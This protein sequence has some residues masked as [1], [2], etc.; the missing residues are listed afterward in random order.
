MIGGVAKL[1]KAGTI[2]GETM[3]ADVAAM[4]SIGNKSYKLLKAGT[5]T[6]DDIKKAIK[7]ANDAI[8]TDI[9]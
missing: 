4:R 9:K 3:A 1:S 2:A 5:N 6:T 7:Y 8:R